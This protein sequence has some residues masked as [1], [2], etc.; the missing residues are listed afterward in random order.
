VA[1]PL[2]AIVERASTSNA[3]DKMTAEPM[4][5]SA[6]ARE[7][8]VAEG[9][10]AFL[11][12]LEESPEIDPHSLIILRHGRVVAAGWWWP[13]GPD[14]RQLLYSVSKSFT[15]TALGLAVAEGLVRLDDE[16]IKYFPELDGEVTD[17]RTRSMR[18]RHI[19]AMASGHIEDTW[20][21]VHSTS[22]DDPVR[23]FLLLP[24]DREPG[25][26]FAYNQPC[27]YT[28]ATIVQ[29]V[30]GQTVTQFLRGR[31]LDRLG[32][33]PV[34]W[35]QHPPGQDLGFSGLHATTDTVA[36]LGQLYLDAGKWKGEQLLSPEWVMEA[37]RRQVSNK[38]VLPNSDWEQGYGF[39]FWMSRHGYRGDGAYG[40]F[41]VVVPENDVVIAMTAQTVEMQAVLNAIWDK[42]LP[43]F[44]EGD[45]PDS[46]A[47]TKLE[48][49]LQR[50]AVP[51]FSAQPAPSAAGEPWVEATFTP[52][53]STP[54][55]QPSLLSVRVSADGGGWEVTLDEAGFS[56]SAPLCNETWV[57][58]ERGTTD[59]DV[60]PNA[61]FGG[62]LDDDTLRFDL[63]FLETPHR[64]TVTCTMPTRTFDAQWVT[65]P[66][67]PPN[68][69][70]LRHMRA[71]KSS[72]ET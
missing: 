65:P 70:A 47:D 51:I 60:V 40:Q 11:D 15:S 3:E 24:P 55:Q 39:Q 17:A 50:L 42:L 58:T 43:A 30:S 7:G 13:Y 44:V 10:E 48:D 2:P 45:L 38:G 21:R 12:V 16:V 68:A 63:I 66:L 71:P 14:R 59:S 69:R 41:C 54:E 19:A 37:T 23:G 22:P 62:W 5:L 25:T 31:L 6:P 1:L 56:L 28:L 36:R 4:P 72:S 46:G 52:A 61:C 57:V 34:S 53:G 9:V 35:A 67:V 26:V 27:T 8:V 29:R 49:R 20:E 33:G 18:V 32:A 64:L